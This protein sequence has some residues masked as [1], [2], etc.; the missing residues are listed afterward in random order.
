MSTPSNE[1]S[2][3]ET[4]QDLEVLLSAAS[5]YFIAQDNLTIPEMFYHREVLRKLT[6]EFISKYFEP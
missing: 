2:T 5:N 4:R 3:D 6:N 1:H